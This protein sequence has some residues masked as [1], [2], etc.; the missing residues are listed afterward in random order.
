MNLIFALLVFPQGGRY[1]IPDAIASG[2]VNIPTIIIIIPLI[3]S[4][5]SDLDGDHYFICWAEDLLPRRSTI[6]CKRSQSP[7]A[8]V[9]GANDSMT[10][11]REEKTLTRD[12]IDY[13]VRNR[14]SP[15]LGCVH[16]EWQA[17][18]ECHSQ[19]TDSTHAKELGALAEILLVC[20]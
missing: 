11:L 13:F 5:L 1:S 12:L 6:P 20:V 2:Y 17:V 16:N 7:T 15:L 8:N 19:M 18:A 9:N 14:H 10:S 3:R 4:L